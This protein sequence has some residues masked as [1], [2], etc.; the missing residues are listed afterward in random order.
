MKCAPPATHKP[1][2][3]S[4]HPYSH[5]N[6]L[7]THSEKDCII[8]Q[9]LWQVAVSQ[10]PDQDHILLQVRVVPLQLTSHDQHLRTYVHTQSAMADTPP[11]HTHTIP[12]HCCLP[13]LH[14]YMHTSIQY[15]AT[16]SLHHMP[17]HP[18]NDPRTSP[19][20]GDQD[21][22]VEMLQI[23]HCTYILYIIIVTGN[24]CTHTV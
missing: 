3:P 11:P 19:A 6:I 18:T 16:P 1:P 24:K 4:S 7:K 12:T 10:G 9:E 13:L 20:D 15:T 22:Y 2:P 5:S 17:D 21:V 8:C 14:L 23:I